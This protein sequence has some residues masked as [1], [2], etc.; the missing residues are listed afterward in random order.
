MR[1]LLRPGGRVRGIVA[2][3]VALTF[4]A[5]G[6]AAG[7]WLGWRLAG[8]L[9]GETQ[10]EV[11]AFD[12]APHLRV[13]G[14]ERVNH[15]FGYGAEDGTPARLLLGG[16]DYDAG[17]TRLDLETND[18]YRSAFDQVRRRLETTGW[19]CRVTDGELHAVRNDVVLSLSPVRDGAL[20]AAPDPAADLALTLRRSEPLPATVFVVLGALTGLLI[21]WIT[22]IRWSSRPAGTALAVLGTTLA[23]PATLLTV[24]SQ[25]LRR[26][27]PEAGWW[28]YMTIGARPLALLGAVLLI[29]AGFRR[30]GPG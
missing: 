2:V 19:E 25:V 15:V 23:L 7:S 11:L 14:S 27:P 1:S 16:Q 8:P 13:I 29:A 30:T 26:I 28:P 20:L 12:A 10:A 3:L 21:G 9:P 17:Y 5:A 18:S 24:A 6:A 4:A 22:G